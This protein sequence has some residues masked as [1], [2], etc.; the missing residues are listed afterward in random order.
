MKRKLSAFACLLFIQFAVKAQM[1]I[2]DHPTTI[3][4]ASLLELE[5]T[6]K[7]FVFPSISLTNVT[8][9][10]PLPTGL[11]TGTVV[12][13][14]NG[15]ITGGNG[16]GLYIWN[17]TL[18]MYLSTGSTSSTAWSLTGNAGTSSGT[19]FLGTTDQQGLTFRVNNEQAG[20]LGISQSSYAT[21]Y[22][23]GSSA[24]FQATAIGAGAQ[25]TGGNAA[26]AVGYQAV[27]N[28][29]NAIAIGIS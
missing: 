7:G 19:N 25:A 29:Q 8:S 6:N 24:G 1:K 11:L 13:N 20:F 22:G 17:G 10:A 27:A 23:V 12:Y 9:A 3:N 16:T 18:W 26:L 21:S 14:I 28:Q 15:S 4:S 2:G 5:S